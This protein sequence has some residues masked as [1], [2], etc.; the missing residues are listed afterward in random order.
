MI[1]NKVR[2][3]FYVGLY[4]SIDNLLI[5]SMARKLVSGS[6]FLMLGYT[7]RENHRM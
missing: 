2:K 3:Y 7:A 1:N 5:V 6:S 4:F